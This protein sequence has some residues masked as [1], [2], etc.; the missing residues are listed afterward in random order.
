MLKRSKAI[1]FSAVLLLGC[2]SLIGC[3]KGKDSKKT[4]IELVHYKPE[5][6]SYF[7]EVEKKFNEKI[8]R[9]HV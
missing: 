3:G 6:V 7:E 1:L 5:A 8:G 2:F 4:K 9:A